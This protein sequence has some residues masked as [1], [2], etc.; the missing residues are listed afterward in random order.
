MKLKPNALGL[1]AGIIWG[2]GLMLVTW[3]SLILYPTGGAILQLI[4]RFYIGYSVSFLGSIIGLIW[5]FID[6]LICGYIFA[7]LY[8]L[9]AK[10]KAS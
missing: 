7:L 4:G 5:G 3:W 1:T 2:V 6:G 8:N 10:E 9:F